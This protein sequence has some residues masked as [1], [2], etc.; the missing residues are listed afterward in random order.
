[1]WLKN[2]F[3]KLVY[4]F[5][6]DEDEDEDNLGWCFEAIN[7]MYD[8]VAEHDKEIILISWFKCNTLL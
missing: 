3:T 4:I 2:Y 1:M 8:T 7:L 5:L 6:V